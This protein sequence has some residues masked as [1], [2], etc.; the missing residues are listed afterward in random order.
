MTTYMERKVLTQRELRLFREL[1]KMTVK[2]LENPEATCHSVCN[3]LSSLLNKYFTHHTSYFGTTHEH[4]WLKFIEQG[5][6]QGD[7]SRVRN[8][9][10]ID[11]YP[12]A[13]D[14]GAI[15]VDLGERLVI[16]TPWNSLYMEAVL[17]C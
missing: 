6:K 7:N 12:V 9:F 10:I 16:P 4:S 14:G 3:D 1:Q 17:P 2:L 5:G 13:V 11:P 8:W 15:I